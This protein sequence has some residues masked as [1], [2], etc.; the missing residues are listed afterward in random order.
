MTDLAGATIIVNGRPFNGTG[1]GFNPMAAARH[2][3]AQRA[4]RRS[5]SI[6]GSDGRSPNAY[7]E[8]ALTPE[9]GLLLRL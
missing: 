4:W 5:R 1:V 8:I 9:S 2:A 6:C 3:A 7:P